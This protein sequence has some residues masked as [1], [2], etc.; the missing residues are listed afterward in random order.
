MAV[1]RGS[2][3]C[4]RWSH[5][6]ELLT[7]LYSVVKELETLFPCRKFTPDGHLVGS[8]GEV[9]AA[10]MFALKLLPAGERCHD[11]EAS[12]GRKVQIKFTQLPRGTRVGLRDKPEH[13]LVIRLTPKRCVDVVYNGPGHVPW[14]E[15]GGR[16]SNGQKPISLNRLRELDA[17]VPDRERLRCSVPGMT[18]GK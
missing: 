6:G 2:Q 14:S 9:I 5:V 8:I 16:Q 4:D 13:L 17:Q 7:Q 12:D 3:A 18:L 15:A 11:A 1:R 10:H